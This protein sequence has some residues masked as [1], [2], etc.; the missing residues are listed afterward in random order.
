LKL[1]IIAGEA[2][3]DLHGSNLIKALLFKNSNLQI[4]AWGGDLMEKA[5]AELV[6]HYKDLA[7][8]GFIEVA[9]NLP[10][11]LSNLSFCKKD[12]Q[13]F[14]TDTLVLIDYPGFNLRIA[15]WAKK[16]GIR[17]IYYISPQVW[18][19]N[20]GRVKKIKR[21]VDQMICILPFEKDFFQDHGMEVSYVGHPLVEAINAFGSKPI[22]ENPK[23]TLLLLPGSR[24]QEIKIML[25]LMLEAAS[26]LENYEITVAGMGSIGREY[27]TAL[28][29]GKNVQLRIDQTYQSMNESDIAWVS[30]GTATLEAALFN[31]PQI[32]CYKGNALSYR[33]AKRLVKVPYISL[34]NLIA[35]KEIIKELIQDELTIENLLSETALLDI[36]KEEIQKQ[37]QQDVISKL[38]DGSSSSQAADIILNLPL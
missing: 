8:M 15:E 16:Q 26:K 4:H 2:S 25:P 21:I 31:L 35:E 12:I 19:W 20:T 29:E 10:T 32:V 18:A 33:L 9:K 37:Y 3:G 23:R 7:F 5:G 27:Y 11:I 6:K 22:K 1:Y 13:A 14:E 30:S 24:K 34:V 38:G 36:N 17:V 28:F